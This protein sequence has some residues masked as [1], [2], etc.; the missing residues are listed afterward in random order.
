MNVMDEKAVK[1]T[2]VEIGML[3]KS[4]ETTIETIDFPEEVKQRGLQ[5]KRKLEAHM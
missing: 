1:L 3:I 4:L 2:K 5:L